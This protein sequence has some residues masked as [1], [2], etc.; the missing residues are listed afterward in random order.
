MEVHFPAADPHQGYD[1]LGFA[2]FLALAL[3]SLVIFG[4]GFNF[5]KPQPATTGLDVTL[6]QHPTGEDIEDADYIAQANQQGSGNITDNKNEITTDQLA[7]YSADVL[8]DTDP[9]LP[10]H[11]EQT[12]SD[13]AERIITS[14]QASRLV[15]QQVAENGEHES[16]S[17]DK[18]IPPALIKEFSS[19]QAQLDT[20]KQAYSKL[21]DILR[22]TSAST[23]Q[24]D[25]AAYLKYWVDKVEL[26]GNTHYPEE[27]RRRKL[28]GE[29]RLAVTVLPDGS[30]ESVEILLA[31]KHRIL[32]QAA[33]ETVRRASPFASFPKEMRQWDKIEIIQTWRFSPD[34][35]L[36][37]RWQ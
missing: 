10:T 27:A 12:V 4:I 14:E 34:N 8:R 13:L 7:D 9:L 26:A 29:L 32:D 36:R 6:A 37:T 15:K 23:R 24:A 5:L 22:L 25:H 3:H 1:R 19:L 30:V 17:I 20:Q 31:S 35:R 2:F 28:F 16:T 21:P 18:E 33:V 11:V